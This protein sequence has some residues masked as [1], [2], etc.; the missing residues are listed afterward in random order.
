MGFLFLF[1]F[2]TTDSYIRNFS[3]IRF[4]DSKHAISYMMEIWKESRKK[5]RRP[6][7][8]SMLHVKRKKFILCLHKI[9]STSKVDSLAL[10][11]A[12]CDL[13]VRIHCTDQH[14]HEYWNLFISRPSHKETRARR[15][16][17]WNLLFKLLL[18]LITFSRGKKGKEIKKRRETT[19]EFIQFTTA[20]S[21]D[22]SSYRARC[23]RAWRR[24]DMPK[25]RNNVFSY[26]RDSWRRKHPTRKVS[27]DRCWPS[28]GRVTLR[29]AA[30]AA[31]RA[32]QTERDVMLAR[33]AVPDTQWAST[34][35][36]TCAFNPPDS[37]CPLSARGDSPLI[38]A[39]H[40]A[41]GASCRARAGE[42]EREK[43]Q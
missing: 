14:S 4:L 32:R 18:S 5:S 36:S 37:F 19:R 12:Q 25:C 30:G 28:R 7:N 9:E 43:G 29:R 22:S 41:N 1:L 8:F 15:V 35:R 39:V 40:D 3:P 33:S 10:R 31:R 26:S 11:I 13:T 42:R 2:P 38:V 20:F 27:R 24:L 6:C 23:D 17:T 16:C 34:K 21:R